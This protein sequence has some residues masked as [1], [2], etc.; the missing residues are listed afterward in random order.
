MPSLRESEQR[1]DGEQRC[2]AGL[3]DGREVP[4]VELVERGLARGAAWNLVGNTRMEGL[5]AECRVA[6]LEQESSIEAEREIRPTRR[7]SSEPFVA[8]PPVISLRSPIGRGFTAT[9]S[10]PNARFP[11]CSMATHGKANGQSCFG[12]AASEIGAQG[13]LDE[14][15]CRL[16][17][18]ARACEEGL[19][20]A[21]LGTL[22][23]GVG[24]GVHTSRW[25]FVHAGAGGR[26]T[27]V[28]G[29]S[30]AAGSRKKMEPTIRL[31]RTTCSLRVS[32][33]TN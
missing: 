11:M 16:S 5:I 14:A 12:P 26:R 32:C 24:N 20:F 15:G 10:H 6:R 19:E 8:L 1:S 18:L 22:S 7:I 31:E 13:L 33:S 27:R 23:R 2:R 4:V 3:G 17:S 21:A 25:R 30:C 28:S 29:G 9:R